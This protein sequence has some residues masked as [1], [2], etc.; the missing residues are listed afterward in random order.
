MTI[1]E[2]PE[3]M[4]NIET[5]MAKLVYEDFGEEEEEV[6]ECLYS[7]DGRVFHAEEKVISVVSETPA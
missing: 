3:D 1:I 5:M 4:R 6:L 2:I 7:G